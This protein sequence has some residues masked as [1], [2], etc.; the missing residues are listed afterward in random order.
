M[1]ASGSDTL[2][3][4]VVSAVIRPHNKTNFVSCHVAGEIVEANDLG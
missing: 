4:R 1:N 3:Y 2:P